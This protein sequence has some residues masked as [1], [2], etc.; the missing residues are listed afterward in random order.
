M[1]GFSPCYLIKLNESLLPLF[2]INLLHSNKLLQTHKQ[3]VQSRMSDRMEHIPLEVHFPNWDQ[4]N[5]S[6]WQRIIPAN[7]FNTITHD[8]NIVSINNLN[9]KRILE[10]KW[11]DVPILATV[12]NLHKISHFDTI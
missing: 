3:A 12:P 11:S 4:N 1:L 7:D 2:T 8:D 10:R 5:R 6:V 9:R